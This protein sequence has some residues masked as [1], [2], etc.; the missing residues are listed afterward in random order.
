MRRAA[1]GP[2][3]EVPGRRLP[4]LHS[5]VKSDAAPYLIVLFLTPV[6]AQLAQYVFP[7]VAVVGAQTLG[8]V[9]AFA[10][11]SIAFVLWCLYVPGHSWPPSFNVFAVALILTWVCTVAASGLHGDAFNLA[12]FLAPVSLFMILLKRP[13][14]RDV[15]RAGD[16][17]AWSL[18]IVAVAAQVLDWVGI[19]QLRYDF[20]NRLPL[21]NEV[22]GPIGRWEGP[23][24]NSN[25][26]G[27]IGAFLVA[28][29]LFRYGL[30]RWAMVIAGGVIVFLSDS[31]TGYL[32]LLVALFVSALYRPYIG[33]L[34]LS[35]K[36]RAIAL[37]LAVCSFVALIVVLDPTINSRTLVWVTYWD[38]WWSSPLVGVGGIG[39]AG[40]LQG[41]LVQGWATHGHNILID[42]LARVGF[43]GLLPLLVSLTSAF[44]L[45]LRAAAAGRQAGLA[46]LACFLAVGF[47]EDVVDWRYLGVQEVPLLLAGMLGVGS[48]V[49]R[50]ERQL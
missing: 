35:S 24:G 8:T 27:P 15:W 13:W 43:L 4:R 47:T 1:I 26:A 6:V 46:I 41:D 33:R 19:R 2:Q 20:W 48:T 50:G 36:T 22:I 37:A 10:G 39:I 18:I 29:G 16:V 42:S 25:L 9:L 28:Y 40:E 21:V 7:G 49:Q 38:L 34:R 31:R 3:I 11:T 17:F 12:A 14:V 5:L 30:S 32:G 23:F 44:V 45:T